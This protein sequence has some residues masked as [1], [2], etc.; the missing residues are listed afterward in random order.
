MKKD[1]HRCTARCATNFEETVRAGDQ[2]VRP[3]EPG[4]PYCWVHLK[5]KQAGKRL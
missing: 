2:C 3:A 5:K 1:Q 4:E